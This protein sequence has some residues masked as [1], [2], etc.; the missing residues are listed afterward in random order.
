MNLTR[1]GGPNFYKLLLKT[2]NHRSSKELN[3]EC[4]TMTHREMLQALL[5]GDIIQVTSTSN[6]IEFKLVMDKEGNIKDLCTDV[7][8]DYPFNSFLYGNRKNL[9]KYEIPRNIVTTKD[10]PW[11]EVSTIEK[12]DRLLDRVKDLEKTIYDLGNKLLQ[13]VP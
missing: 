4:K 9:G 3:K 12:C 11:D 13:S 10:L 1:V 7:F 2:S 6:G 8:V 5:D